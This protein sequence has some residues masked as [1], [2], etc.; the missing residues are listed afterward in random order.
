MSHACTSA[1]LH[2]EFGHVFVGERERERRQPQLKEGVW[3]GCL[4]F[5]SRQL[6]QL[7]ETRSLFSTLEIITGRSTPHGGVKGQTGNGSVEEIHKI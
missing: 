6:G 7:T 1:D 2:V 3:T 4:W 5:S